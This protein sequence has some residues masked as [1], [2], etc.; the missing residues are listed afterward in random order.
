M[1]TINKTPYRFFICDDS[2]EL[3]IAEKIFAKFLANDLLRKYGC[4]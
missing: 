1:K 3:D 4:E 2:G